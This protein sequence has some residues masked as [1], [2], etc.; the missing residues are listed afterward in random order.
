MAQNIKLIM[1][2]ACRGLHGT[3]ELREQ[4]PQAEA[5]HRSTNLCWDVCMNTSQTNM[6]ALLQAGTHAM[7]DQKPPS[8]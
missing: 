8:K 6:T 2:V 1:H 5:N 3:P 7:Q 4:P